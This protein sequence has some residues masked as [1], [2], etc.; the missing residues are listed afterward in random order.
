MKAATYSRRGRRRI[1][2]I[3][4]AHGGVMYLFIHYTTY[5]PFMSQTVCKAGAGSLTYSN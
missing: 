2:Y 4:V 1:T 3:K 5:P